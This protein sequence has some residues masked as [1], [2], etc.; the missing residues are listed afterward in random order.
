MES[1]DADKRAKLVDRL[2]ASPGYV[3]HQANEFDT[4]LATPGGGGKRNPGG[5]MRDY[6]LRIIQANRPWDQ[7]FRDLILADEKEPIQKGASQFLRVRLRDMDRLTTDVSILFFGVNISC[8]QCHDHPLVPA[9]KQDHYFGLKSFFSRS[10]E[11]GGH[12]GEREYAEVKFMTTK[13]VNKQAQ[14]MFLTGKVVEDPFDKLSPEE[15]KKV[16]QN[17]KPAR[18]GKRGAKGGPPPPAPP[19]FSA[20]AA[21]ADLALQPE[22]RSFFARSIVN[23]LWHRLYGFGLVHPI[24]QMHSENSPSHPQLLDWLARDFVDHKYDTKRL[25][26]GLVMSKAYSRSSRWEGGRF[27]QPKSFAVARLRALTPLQMTASMRIAMADLESLK[28]TAKPEELEKRIEGLE[29]QGRGFASFIE[30]P[31][32]DFQIGVGEALLFSNSDRIQ[33]EFLGDGGDRLLG[34]LKTIKEPEAR[35]ELAVRSVLSRPAT[36][37]EKKV[38]TAYLKAREDRL[39]EANKQMV[40][41]L[42]T[43]SE[44]RFNY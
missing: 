22:Q 35:V 41:A 42:L 18:G 43:C 27:P 23:R 3:R 6:L 12:V 40:W 38:L 17:S 21:L 4:L 34:R 36:A 37:E 9:W 7:V 19:K 11:T 16:L 20:R 30:Q 26:R 32:D 25:I 28:P 13:R 33:Q 14:L 39:S 8:A 31:R 10:F 5:S 44:F 15:K 24:D 2:M 1:K 29:N